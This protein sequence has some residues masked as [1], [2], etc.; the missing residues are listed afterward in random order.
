MGVDDVEAVEVEVLEE[1]EGEGFESAFEL[2]GCAVGDGGPRV[3]EVDLEVEDLV[4][5][6]V[7]GFGVVGV[8]GSVS[9]SVDFDFDEAGEFSGE[10]LDVDAGSSVDV[11][12]ILA[13]HEAYTHGLFSPAE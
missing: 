1:V 3:L 7:V 6:A 12:G 13:S 9:P 5:V 4:G 8:G 2:G 10:V 11:R